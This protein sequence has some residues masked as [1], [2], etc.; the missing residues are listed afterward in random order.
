MQRYI[1]EEFGKSAE[2]PVY[3]PGDTIRLR[4][5]ITHEVNLGSVWAVFRRVVAVVVGVGVGPKT[6][7]EEVEVEEVGGGG[8]DADAEEDPYN[9]NITLAGK[10]YALSRAGA[11][12]ASEVCF[13]MEVS[14]E[15]HLPG[16]YELEAVRAY[17]YDL[18][19]REDQILE[20]EFKGEIRFRIVGENGVSSPTVTGWKFD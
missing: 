20:F 4:L 10:H 2:L 16:E 14:R 7:E 3:V 8:A 15:E 17:P 13:E 11:M 5:R 9:N 12:R 6:Q 19:G 18:D 1:E